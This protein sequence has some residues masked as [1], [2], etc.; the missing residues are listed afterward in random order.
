MNFKKTLKKVFPTNRKLLIKQSLK[1]I[2]FENYDNV[3]VVGAGDDPY[4]SLFKN[5]KEYVCV[6]KIVT[7]NIT[8]VIADAQDLPLDNNS[9]DCIFSSEVFEHLEF[10]EKFINEGYR[11]LSN[12]GLF[13]IT[14]PF[15]F[16]EHADPHDYWRPTTQALHLLFREFT[17][18][19]IIPQGNRIHV[20]LD[21]ITTSTG[22]FSFFFPLRIFNHLIARLPT[23][24]KTSAPSGFLVIA[25]KKVS[26]I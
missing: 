13:V 23:I 15:L 5:Y 1:Y 7:P 25:R 8:D 2:Q 9:F 4:R 17:Q 21:L 11:I 20:L 12:N 19:K 3:L 16:H 18:V 24:G 6:D 10:P 26:I 14:V 22:K